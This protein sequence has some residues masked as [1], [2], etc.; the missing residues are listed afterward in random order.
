MANKD[1]P[2]YRVIR[3]VWLRKIQ[4]YPGYILTD[5]DVGSKGVEG[6]KG[7]LKQKAIEE[8]R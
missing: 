5:E 6:I 4:R 8:I 2:K 1:K 7:L 3:I